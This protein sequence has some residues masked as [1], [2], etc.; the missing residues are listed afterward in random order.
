MRNDSRFAV[1]ALTLALAAALVPATAGTILAADSPDPIGRWNGELKVGGTSLRV[2]FNI[3]GGNGQ[4]LKVTMDSLD[5]GARDIPGSIDVKADQ[6]EIRVPSIQGRFKGTFAADGR[7]LAGT[8]TQSGHD[9]PLQL[10]RERVDVKAISPAAIAS[11]PHGAAL[12]GIWLGALQVGAMTLRLQFHVRDEAGE[13]LVTMDSLDQ[14]AKGIAALAEL[15]SDRAVVFRVPSVGGQFAGT[16]DASGDTLHGA[17]GQSGQSFPLVLARSDG[18]VA[19]P[20]PQEPRPPFPYREIEVTLPGGAP[21]VQLAGT[22]TL[23]AGD[24]PFPAVVLVS[25]SG[26]QDRN[27]EIMGH[28]PFLVLADYLTRQGLAVLRCDDRGT[29][30]STGSFAGATTA[31]FADDAEAAF[32]FLQA[33]PEIRRDAV[34]I[35]GHSEGGLIAPMIAARRPDVGFIVLLA[36]PGVE[37]RDVLQLQTVLLLRAGGAPEEMIAAQSR[38]LET[39]LATVA[40]NHDPAN[41]R[42]QLVADLT[43]AAE[44]AGEVPDDQQIGQMATQFSG[45]W[46]RYFLFHDPAPGLAAVTCPVLAL[47]GS[48]D[49]QVDPAQNLPAIRAALEQGGNPHFEV[50]ELPGLNH[51][52]QTAQTGATSEYAASEETMAPVALEAIG[53][54]I[55]QTTGL[56]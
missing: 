34:G 14:G 12:P 44:A 39:A 4:R 5:Q 13:L 42:D 50:R 11:Q 56:D 24:G 27:E 45:A 43:A 46:F 29:G 49:L 30:S 10:K 20:R 32:D 23:P 55:R 17:W 3:T 52:F 40:A 1:L 2:R 47:N 22:L 36:G 38:Q 51:L 9:L 53:G 31:D 18:A 54:W 35:L 48:L 21:E 8:W 37:G 15:G 16:L 33:R 25:G 7:T 19:P 41:L 6:A 28:K 26:P